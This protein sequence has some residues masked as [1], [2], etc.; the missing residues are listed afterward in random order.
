VDG[1]TGDAVRSPHDHNETVRCA[2]VLEESSVGALVEFG[3]QRGRAGSWSAGADFTFH[4]SNFGDEKNLLIGVWGMMT[5][6]EDLTGDKSAIGFRFD[7]PNDLVEL[8]F[9]SIRI[10]NGFD[11][12]LAFVPRNGVHL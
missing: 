1:S 12:S 9:N 11:P 6:R 3:D 8:T 7:Y 2:G 4:T 10:G 5:D